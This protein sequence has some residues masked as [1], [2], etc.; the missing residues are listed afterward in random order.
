MAHY[1]GCLICQALLNS[2]MNRFP[3]ARHRPNLMRMPVAKRI[4]LIDKLPGEVKICRR[5]ST[6]YE[7]ECNMCPKTP[8]H[9]ICKDSGIHPIFCA[10]VDCTQKVDRWKA[11]YNKILSTGPQNINQLSLDT[12]DKTFLPI[13]PT[14]LQ[15]NEHKEE[16]ETYDEEPEK[17]D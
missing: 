15:H 5:C 8:M 14:L 16:E 11:T 13:S 1:T 10:C 2:R 6:V 4:Q 3:V 17:N 12:T 9:H 7:K